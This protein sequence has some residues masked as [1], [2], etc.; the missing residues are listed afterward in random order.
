MEVFMSGTRMPYFERG[1]KS[2]GGSSRLRSSNFLVQRPHLGFDPFEGVLY[3]LGNSARFFAQSLE[4]THVIHPRPFV[5]F[6]RASELLSDGFGSELAQGYAPL[7][8]SRFCAAKNLVRDF[9]RRLHGL[10]LAHLLPE[11]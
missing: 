9:Q 10:M 7:R 4:F 1:G 11:R 6:G 2:A 3:D 5:Y 8:R